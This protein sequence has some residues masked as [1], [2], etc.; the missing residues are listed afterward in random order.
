[1]PFTSTALI[2]RHLG[3]PSC[4]YDPTGLVQKNDRAAH[5]IPIVTGME[6]LKSWFD[7]PEKNMKPEIISKKP[8]HNKK[9]ERSLIDKI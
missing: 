7:Q 5:G 2:A 8:E 4:Y 1:M 9:P 6:E 3:K